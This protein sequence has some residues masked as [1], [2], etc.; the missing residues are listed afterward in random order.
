LAQPKKG[1]VMIVVKDVEIIHTNK[2]H[3]QIAHMRHTDPWF[4][5]EESTDPTKVS[6]DTEHISGVRIR[7][8][9]GEEVILGMSKKVQ[10]T[11]GIPFHLFEKEMPLMKQIFD[12]QE[13][14]DKSYE[15]YKYLSDKCYDSEILAKQYYANLD[16]VFHLSWWQRLKFCLFGQRFLKETS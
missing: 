12:L 7:N 3:C 6:V 4:R 15:E 8:V 13:K 2:P 10:D 5:E 1:E 16:K 11:L 14:L 9:D